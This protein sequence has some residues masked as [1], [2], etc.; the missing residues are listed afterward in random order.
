MS[1]EIQVK[2]TEKM[3]TRYVT[4]R[5]SGYINGMSDWVNITVPERCFGSFARICEIFDYLEET[6]QLHCLKSKDDT[7]QKIEARMIKSPDAQTWG[8]TIGKLLE[9]GHALEFET[10]FGVKTLRAKHVYNALACTMFEESDSSS[11]S[12]YG[13]AFW[14]KQ[15][16]ANLVYRI[17]FGTRQLYLD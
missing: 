12:F 8:Q 9:T 10:P 14:T 7:A 2:G 4:N 6:P 13:Y 3:R 5:D 17:F 15:M 11:T 1:R 16:R